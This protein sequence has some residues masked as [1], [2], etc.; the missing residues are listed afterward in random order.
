MA[1]ME[2]GAAPPLP[3]PPPA[4]S[5]TRSATRSGSRRT[6]TEPVATTTLPS[7][8]SLSPPHV[9]KRTIA[10][11][12]STT[13]RASRTTKSIIASPMPVATID[14][15]TPRNDP[16]CVTKPRGDVTTF[17]PP[18][19]NIAAMRAARPTSPTDSTRG[20]TSAARTRR[21]NTRP[22]A[23]VG[24]FGSTGAGGGGGCTAARRARSASVPTSATA[25]AAAAEAEPSQFMGRGAARPASYHGRKASAKVAE[26]ITS[27][28]A[29]R[30]ARA[31]LTRLPAGLRGTPPRP[32]ASRSRARAS[33]T[34]S[35][36][37]R[38]GHA[39]GAAF[40]A[41]LTP[42]C[43]QVRPTTPEE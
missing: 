21:W 31:R 4:A 13:A 37:P 17:E 8:T 14:T 28:H 43:P 10:I 6:S 9:P 23:S 1:E 35:E 40:C 24:A 5:R 2:Y 25:A 32:G 22:S 11:G 18:S 29:A 41:G 30:K 15:R 19:S 26:V 34:R 12:P 33:T 3:R 42:A 39:G 27:M 16:V 7:R 38:V 36:R 20:A